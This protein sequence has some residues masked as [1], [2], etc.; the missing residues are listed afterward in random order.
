MK[1]NKNY[2]EKRRHFR[3]EKNLP[4]KI[5]G[6]E[7]DIVTETKNI[8]CA[9]AY[10]K[11]DRYVAPFTKVKTTIL[12][13]P[14]KDESKCINCKGVVVR[15]EKLNNI[16]EPQYNIAIYFNEISKMNILKISRFVKNHPPS[17]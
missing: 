11:V 8:C 13:S 16:L 15:V 3:L 17:K 2:P 1:N 4:I 14:T 10:C 12:L 6:E 9:G 7:F 5:K